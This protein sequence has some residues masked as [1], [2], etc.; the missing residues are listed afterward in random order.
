[1][2]EDTAKGLWEIH[3]WG[4]LGCH[5]KPGAL[6]IENED[7]L[8]EMYI[9]TKTTTSIDKTLIKKHLKEWVVI[10]WCH[11]EEDYKLVIKNKDWNTY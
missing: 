1:M 10:D 6:I 7:N 2:A 11:I 8:D 9:K 5:K 4:N 3:S